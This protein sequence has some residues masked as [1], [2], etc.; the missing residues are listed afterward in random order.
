MVSKK[1]FISKIISYFNT[2]MQNMKFTKKNILA[3]IA[4]S[5]FSFTWVFAAWIDHF[6]VNFFPE[7]VKVWEALDLTIEAVDKNN[8][9]ILDYEGTI[10]IFSESDPEAELPSELE[11]NTYEF[12]TSD[13]WKIKFENAVKFKNAWLQNIHIYDLNDDAV[14]WVAEVNVT[15]DD[16][17]KII[18]IAIVSP[19][20]GLTIWEN[21]ISVSWTTQKN[22]QVQVIINWSD[23]FDTTSNNDWIF[24][25]SIDNLNDWDN[26]IKAQVLDSDWNIVWETDIKNIRVD[27][28]SLNIKNVKLTPE[29]VDPESSF[30]I[31]VIANPDLTEVNA[32]VNDVL[33]ILSETTAWTYI[34]K[35]Y[36]PK[37]SWTYKVDIQIK[38]EL[39][40]E[41]TELGAASLVVKEIEL[42][43]AAEEEDEVVEDEVAKDEEL[44]RDLRI[45]WLKL[46]ELK[47][48]SIL[49]WDELYDIESYN[50]YKKISEWKLELVENV[51][52]AQ[53]EVEIIWDKIKYDFFAVKAVAKTNSWDLYEWALSDATKIKTG[54][55]I[56]ILFILSL[57]I[58]WFLL[59]T[60]QKRA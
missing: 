42:E 8:V 39:G 33:I 4:S 58:G 19:E 23:V 7:N 12:L 28:S 20:N 32:I 16:T 13:Q 56:L 45:T 44:L 17:N 24:E 47:T 18:D 27:L 26:T 35:T 25:K 6:E 50:I 5:M 59:I 30:E 53:F 34:V 54:P 55:E 1:L 14:F 43:S 60:K 52:N 40:H 9:T 49:T 51:K 29:S 11:E 37:A 41:K 3:F 10:L 2:Y 31:E 21:S 15:Q 46:V 22:H 57:M 38:D 36:A 48:K